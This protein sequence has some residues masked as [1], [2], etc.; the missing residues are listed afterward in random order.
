MRAFQRRFREQDAIVGDD[1]DFYP[2]DMR[3][4]ADQGGAVAGLEFVEIAAVDDARDHLAHVERLARIDG[5]HAIQFL[6]RVFRLD[7][8][9]QIH[10]LRFFTVQV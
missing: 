5:D 4:A 1:A 2:I 9:A 6:R 10:L 8:G 3:K 7:G